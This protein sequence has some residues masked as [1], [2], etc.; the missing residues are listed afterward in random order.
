M[1]RS[2]GSRKTAYRPRPRFRSENLRLPQAQRPRAKD[3]FFRDRSAQGRIHAN[4]DQ[5]AG[6]ITAEDANR[7]KSCAHAGNEIRL[8]P[9][10][11]ARHHKPS[12]INGAAQA[13]FGPTADMR[14][15]GHVGYVP[16]VLQK[17]A[18]T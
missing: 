4:S 7:S 14:R 12:M 6:R 16:I 18:A 8:S 9:D 2:R 5:A 13:R 11:N 10:R 17:S 1:G 3:K 15:A